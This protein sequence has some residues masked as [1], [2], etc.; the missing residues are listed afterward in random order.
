[1]KLNI[2]EV[3]FLLEAAKAV[4]IKA[5]DAPLVADC[6]SKLNKEFERLAKLEEKKQAA[7]PMLEAAK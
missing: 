4:N 6:M 3:N 5:V 7:A 1:M 2:N